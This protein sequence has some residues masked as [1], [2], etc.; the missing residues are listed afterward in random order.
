M[1]S[2]LTLRRSFIRSAVIAIGLSLFLF[3][4]SDVKA[5]NFR[6]EFISIPNAKADTILPKISSRFPAGHFGVAE[7]GSPGRTIDILRIEAENACTGE[8]CP[9]IIVVSNSGWSIIIMAD[10]SIAVENPVNDMVGVIFN[11]QRGGKT[12]VRLNYLEKTVEIIH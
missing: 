11:N 4:P 6:L 8:I 3:S 10:K 1:S 2:F 7:I 9:T 5:T 12:I